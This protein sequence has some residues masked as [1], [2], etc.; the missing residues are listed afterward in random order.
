MRRTAD[1]V[2]RE[3]EREGERE[4]EREFIEKCPRVVYTHT[5]IHTRK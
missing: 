5:L 4:R 3:R 1:K 2:V